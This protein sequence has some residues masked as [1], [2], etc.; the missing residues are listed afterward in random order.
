M[1]NP[2]ITSLLAEW[3]NFTNEREAE[4]YRLQNPPGLAEKRAELAEL[5]QEIARLKAKQHVLKAKIALSN[6]DEPY[7]KAL[8]DVKWSRKKQTLKDALESAFMVEIAGGK[9]IPSI[10]HDYNMRNPV[11]LYQIKDKVT[12]HQMSE[13]TKLQRVDW[14]WSNFTGTH[15]YALAKGESGEW[16][17]VQMR[18]T[19]GTDV[20]GE[21]A[22]WEIATGELLTGS[23]D[24]FNSDSANGREKRKNTLA[25][26]LDGTYTGAYKESPNPYYGEAAQ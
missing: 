4:R 20:E 25:S 1:A 24:V 17:Y 16:A 5:N 7:N 26:V 21:K 19:L 23:Q 6:Q 8:F 13:T 11:W 3:S 9:S 14:Q 2:K 10:M 18:G 15:R 22:I 12:H